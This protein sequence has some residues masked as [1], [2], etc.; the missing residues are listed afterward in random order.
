[1]AELTNLTVL[2]LEDNNISD[3]SPLVANKGLGEGDRIY[4]D[5][6]PLNAVSIDT[7]IPALRSRGVQVSAKNLI[8]TQVV[9]VP[10][11]NLRAAIESALG[12]A[13]GGAITVEQMATLTTLEAHDSIISNLTG[14]EY[15]ANLSYLVLS[16]NN[17][18]DISALTGL[19]NLTILDLHG[20]SITDISA[21]AGLTNLTSLT[22]GGTNISDISPVA[23]LTNLTRLYLEGTNISDISALAGLTSLTSLEF[24]D[25]NISDISPLAG[26]TNLTVLELAYNKISDISALAGLTNLTYLTLIGSNIEN[27]SPLVANTGFGE[28]DIIHVR[29]NPLNAVSID[30]HIPALESRGVEVYFDNRTPPVDSHSF[31]A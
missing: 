25:T 28:G 6:N 9:V 24:Y 20:N 10:D 5:R 19:T 17:I 27:L 14:L 4:V 15:A 21:L 11:P 13:S 3:I 16:R 8:T 18:S 29:R 26:L 30:T 1:M 12:I 31:G 23:G 22:L 2:G 7:H